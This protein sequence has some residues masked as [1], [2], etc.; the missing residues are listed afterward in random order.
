VAPQADH[1]SEPHIGSGCAKPCDGETATSAVAAARP[2]GSASITFFQSE[3]AAT[4]TQTTLSVSVAGATA[5]K[6]R[7]SA[8]AAAEADTNPG[9]GDRGVSRVSSGRPPL[10]RW[11]FPSLLRVSDE[12]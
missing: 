3:Q 5:E 10:A 2:S 6:T 8:D 11:R 1:N 7:D 12:F 9:F 4:T